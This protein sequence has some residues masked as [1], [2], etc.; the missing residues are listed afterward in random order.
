MMK[1]LGYGT[2]RVVFKIDDDRVVKIPFNNNGVAQN[3]QE[4]ELSKSTTHNYYT[5]VYELNEHNW[6]YAEYVEDCSEQ[7][8]DYVSDGIHCQKYDEST[9][10]TITFNCDFDCIN[11]PRNTCED[12][13]DV[14]DFLANKP[15]DRLQVGR[16]KDGN[17]KYF[18]YAVGEPNTPQLFHNGMLNAFNV[19]LEQKNYDVLFIDWLNNNTQYVRE[20]YVTNEQLKH[21][22]KFKRQR[23]SMIKGRV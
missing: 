10:L 4:W 17:L 1:Y 11:C 7:F 23:K 22:N 5:K 6:L 13:G 8:N 15:K 14:K 18:D 3:K 19:Y 16:D 20:A 12:F 21:A 2:G 9:E